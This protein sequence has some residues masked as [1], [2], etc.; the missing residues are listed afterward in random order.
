MTSQEMETR[1][2]CLVCW[3]DS[4]YSGMT[5]GTDYSVGEAWSDPGDV[6]TPLLGDTPSVIMN[7][8][9]LYD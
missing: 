3:E 6:Q 8:P 7:Y 5:L 1:A 9:H 2:A 4:D